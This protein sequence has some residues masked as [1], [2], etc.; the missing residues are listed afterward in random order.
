MRLVDP[1]SRRLPHQRQQALILLSLLSSSAFLL[2]HAQTGSFHNAPASAENV[3]NP[4]AGQADAVVAGKQVY[5]RNCGAC[6]GIA[7][8]GTGN[9]PSL[10]KGKAQAA[11]AGS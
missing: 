7:G 3:Q 8:N 2:L 11:S 6:H 10:A 4:Y 5:T 1:T 9:V